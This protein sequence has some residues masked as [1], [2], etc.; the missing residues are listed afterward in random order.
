[1]K[2]EVDRNRPGPSASEGVY[3]LSN[4]RPRTTAHGRQADHR[5][6][7]GRCAGAALVVL[8][9]ALLPGAARA[10]YFGQNKVQYGQHSWRSISADHFEVYF[11]PGLDSLAM[12]V[13]DLAE[14]THVYLSQRM[15]HSVARRVP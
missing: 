14:K 3:T 8:G 2:P 10:Q 4:P 11:Y 6:R 5:M 9:L 7:R 12:R 13:L 1:M 15:G